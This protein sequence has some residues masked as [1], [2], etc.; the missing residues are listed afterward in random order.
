MPSLV[1]TMGWWGYTISFLDK[2]NP[3]QFGIIWT[4]D[5]DGDGMLEHIKLPHNRHDAPV[6]NGK[7]IYKRIFI[8]PKRI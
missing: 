6:V 8:K 2:Y 1:I 4:T 5:R 7:G 3:E